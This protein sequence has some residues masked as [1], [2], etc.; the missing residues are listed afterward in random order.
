MT[1][2]TSEQRVGTTLADVAMR[3]S[4]PAPG[5]TP[6]PPG[7]NPSPP[8][9]AAGALPFEAEDLEVINSGT[10]T[11]L[12]LDPMTSGGKWVALDAENAGSW[13][14]FTL[15]NVPAGNYQLHITHKTNS[16]RGQLISRIDGVQVG[17]TL[18]QYAT[19]SSYPTT[20]MGSASLSRD[21]D[22]KVRMVAVGKQ[23]SSQ[24]FVL[25][26]DRLALVPTSEEVPRAREID[27]PPPIEDVVGHGCTSATSAT[28]TTPAATV[29][30][31]GQLCWAWA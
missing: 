14:E 9:P 31:P 5:P 16:N 8:P 10:G 26:A 11:S 6:E 22:R 2:L 7:P 12:Q 15:P 19:D 13:M 30:C 29:H 23:D 28:S 1:N 4:A 3:G 21:G 25:S 27:N 24:G 20:V 18:D 17:E